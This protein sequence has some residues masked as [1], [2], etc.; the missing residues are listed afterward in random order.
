MSV[1][2]LFCS[3]RKDGADSV[4]ECFIKFALSFI[5]VGEVDVITRV[6][7]VRGESKFLWCVFWKIDLLP[8]MPFRFPGLG[9][10]W[11]V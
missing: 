6:L 7:E 1:L 5:V 4:R 9:V 2:F 10:P 8:F 3:L 11:I